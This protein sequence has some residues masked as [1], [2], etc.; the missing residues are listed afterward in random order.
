MKNECSGGKD[1]S[2]QKENWGE[3]N[4]GER[5]ESVPGLSVYSYP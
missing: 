5:G 3:N 4:Q 1:N 2:G